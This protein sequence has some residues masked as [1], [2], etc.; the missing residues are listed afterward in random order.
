M[1]FGIFIQFNFFFSNYSMKEVY[2]LRV[3][4][5]VHGHVYLNVFGDSNIVKYSSSMI[6]CKAFLYLKL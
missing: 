5:W 1:L 3:G 6:L 2:F 4:A